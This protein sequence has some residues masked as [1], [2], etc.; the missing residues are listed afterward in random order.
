MK[1]LRKE[2]SKGTTDLH[3][4][5]LNFTIREATTIGLSG[6]DLARYL[7]REIG[8]DMDEYAKRKGAQKRDLGYE[9]GNR[10][11]VT[12]SFQAGGINEFVDGLLGLK[13][14]SVAK[15]KAEDERFGIA[16]PH[17]SFPKF[18]P[19]IMAHL[20]PT[21]TSS[22]VLVLGAPDD[23]AETRC[24]VIFLEDCQSRHGDRPL[25]QGLRGRQ[26]HCLS[27]LP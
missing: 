16:L 12:G 20:T 23:G 17:P 26:C 14:L 9:S 3:N 19:G 11:K 24:D 13:P 27:R 5:S 22:C 2:F 18:Q 15:L 10:T 7:E 1:R 25:R 4:K 6:D 21:P 8:P